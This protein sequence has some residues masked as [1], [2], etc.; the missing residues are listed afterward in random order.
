[1]LLQINVFRDNQ[2]QEL[3]KVEARALL[4]LTSNPGAIFTYE[5]ILSIKDDNQTFTL[6]EQEQVKLLI[7]Q[8][9]KGGQNVAESRN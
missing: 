7:T 8:N 9:Q 2:I 4:D 1:M 6:E 5:Q 3:D